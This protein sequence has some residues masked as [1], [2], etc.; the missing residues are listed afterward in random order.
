MFV[1][2]AHDRSLSDAATQGLH[3]ALREEHQL[4]Q[5]SKMT[6]TTINVFQSI[7]L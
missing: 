6:S 4:G 7:L 5:R 3:E 1:R 2:V